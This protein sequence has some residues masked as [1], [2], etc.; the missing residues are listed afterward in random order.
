MSEL[1]TRTKEVA[2]QR[3]LV[4]LAIGL[5]ICLSRL[6]PGISL[7]PA[8]ERQGLSAP[9][10]VY[11]WLTGQGRTEGLYRIDPAFLAQPEKSSRHG[12]ADFTLPEL[13]AIAAL[14]LEPGQSATIIEPPPG[15]APFF[16]AP[17]A[18]NRADRELLMTIPGIG[19]A[20]ADAII[21]LRQQ[22]GKLKEPHELLE[23][24]GIGKARLANLAGRF[25]YD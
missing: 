21:A 2:E 16:F 6:L 22:K 15:L 14:R 3:L 12:L 25:T 18:V 13:R 4:M 19:P 5:A 17:I 24:K 7:F 20:L 1:R 9:G 11:C 10:P 8:S 23:A